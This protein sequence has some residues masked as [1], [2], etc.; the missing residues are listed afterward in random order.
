LKTCRKGPD[1]DKT[2]GFIAPAGQTA[3]DN[4]LPAAGQPA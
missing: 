2:V 4:C 1:V 3:A